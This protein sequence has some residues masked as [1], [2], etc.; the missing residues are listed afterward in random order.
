MMARRPKILVVDDNQSLRQSI[1]DILTWKEYES[2]GAADGFSG[3]RLAE[4]VQPNLIILDVMM[5]DIDGI[6]VLR[7]LRSKPATRH[8]PVILLTGAYEDQI[9]SGL[10][11]GIVQFVS[12]PFDVD[13]L[14]TIIKAH[15]GAAPLT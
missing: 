6:S 4:E 13:E 5:P 15:L 14:L 8:T 12:K 1:L 3:I 11:L 10:E 9:P 2:T 7:I